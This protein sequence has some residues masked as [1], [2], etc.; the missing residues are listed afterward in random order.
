MT[1]EEFIKMMEE[2]RAAEQQDWDKS[3][4]QMILSFGCAIIVFVLIVIGAWLIT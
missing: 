1:R 2:I 3:K 4:G